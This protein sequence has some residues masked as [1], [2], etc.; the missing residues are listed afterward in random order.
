MC[1]GC[2]KVRFCLPESKF[3]EGYSFME[4][5]AP[6][7]VASCFYLQSSLEIN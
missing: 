6:L 7:L 1:A 4:Y 3:L 2:T 5:G